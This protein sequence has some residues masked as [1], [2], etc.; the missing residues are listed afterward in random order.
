[1][2]YYQVTT[3]NAHCITRE[4]SV[5]VVFQKLL[6]DVDDEK[7]DEGVSNFLSAAK[8]I[9]DEVIGKLQER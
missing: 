8:H 4:N 2:K 9:R 6:A 7:F 1:M 3:E 5:S